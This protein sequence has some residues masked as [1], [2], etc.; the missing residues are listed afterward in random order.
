MT[1]HE[2]NVRLNRYYFLSDDHY[3]HARFYEEDTLQLSVAVNTVVP[4]GDNDENDYRPGQSES[5]KDFFQLSMFQIWR[6]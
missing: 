3:Q 6:Q 5:Q 1:S 4:L 2:V